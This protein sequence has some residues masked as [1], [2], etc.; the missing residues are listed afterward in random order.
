MN[1]QKVSD[2]CFTS[3][4]LLVIFRQKQSDWLKII[5]SELVV[6]S[7]DQDIYVELVFLILFCLF[8]YSFNFSS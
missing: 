7:S 1:V 2:Q 3:Y 8:I 5:V 6:G 4:F